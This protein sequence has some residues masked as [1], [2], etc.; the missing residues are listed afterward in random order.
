MDC[1]DSGNRR[2]E[3]WWK[4][5]CQLYGDGNTALVM[6]IKGEWL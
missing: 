6:V 2:S 5:L 4:I 1:G 3:G